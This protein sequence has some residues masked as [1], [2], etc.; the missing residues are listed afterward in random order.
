[1]A[2][3]IE[4]MIN[5]GPSATIGL[6]IGLISEPLKILDEDDAPIPAGYM[7]ISS[8]ANWHNYGFGLGRDYAFIREQIQTLCIQI[9]ANA[10]SG[11][12][13]D[14]ALVPE[15]VSHVCIAKTGTSGLFIG[16]EGLVGIKGTNWAFKPKAY[17]GYELSDM[18]TRQILAIYAIGSI[19]DRIADFGMS[20]IV[21]WG[22][23]YHTSSIEARRNRLTATS[24]SIFNEIPAYAYLVLG[25]VTNP[26]YRNMYWMYETFGVKGIVEDKD[27]VRN[28][29]PGPGILDY[30]LARAP[31]NSIGLASKNWT[32]LSNG[33]NMQVFANSLYAILHKGI[34]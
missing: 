30:I 16:K 1:M 21:A 33:A 2:R 25:D 29:N 5:G 15:S 6:G 13:A 23:P 3:L 12:Y 22:V 10:C 31:Y 14:P 20:Q 27:L 34:Y 8:I 4:H 32:T 7:D 19:L 28:P 24:I 18:P 26:A 9:G 17:Y 11:E